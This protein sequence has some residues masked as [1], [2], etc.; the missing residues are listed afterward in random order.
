MS[1]KPVSVVES[2]KAMSPPV[3]ELG[4]VLGCGDRKVVVIGTAVVT[5]QPPKPEDAKP[6]GPMPPLVLEWRYLVQDAG[7]A[8]RYLTTTRGMWAEGDQLT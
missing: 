6:D 2:I 5:Y 3:H 7:G 4:A 8:D 1:K